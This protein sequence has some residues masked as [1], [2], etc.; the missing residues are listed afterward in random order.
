MY[1]Y[2]A[3]MRGFE[4]KLMFNIVDKVRIVSIFYLLKRFMIC[5]FTLQDFARAVNGHNSFGAAHGDAQVVFSPD[6]K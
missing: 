1:F 2:R 6:G 4:I 3:Y 5:I